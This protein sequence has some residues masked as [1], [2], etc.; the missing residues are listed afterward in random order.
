M[1]TDN[2][3]VRKLNPFEIS[4]AMNHRGKGTRLVSNNRRVFIC[5]HLWYLS[6]LP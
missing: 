1:D 5:V 3:D 4:T 2:T 6:Q